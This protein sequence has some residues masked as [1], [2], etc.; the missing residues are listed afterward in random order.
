MKYR[1]KEINCKNGSSSFQVQAFLLFGWADYDPPIGAR[2][3]N[4]LEKAQSE[5]EI[6]KGR[7]K[8]GT[9]YHY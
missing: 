4:T 3:Y 2:C 1:V 6:L 8:S 7:A 9:K 5:I